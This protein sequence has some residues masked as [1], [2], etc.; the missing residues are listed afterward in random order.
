M[1]EIIV[2]ILATMIFWEG[3]GLGYMT[4]VLKRKNSMRDNI[5]SNMT[6][7]ERT[8]A[9]MYKIFDKDTIK[10][11]TEQWT[12]EA[13]KANMTLTEYLEFISPLAGE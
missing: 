9:W 6:E 2:A 12:K 5:F 10:A 8:L 11:K 3:Y 7:E 13:E 4:G 1:D